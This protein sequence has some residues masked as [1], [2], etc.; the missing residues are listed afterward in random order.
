MSEDQMMKRCKDAKFFGIGYLPDYKLGFTRYSN[1]RESAVA[2]ILVYPGEN[3]WGILYSL[4]E[5]DIKELDKC[6]G[7]P[8]AYRRIDERAMLFNDPYDFEKLFDMVKENNFEILKTNYSDKNNYKEVNVITYEVVNKNV[9]KLYPS[10]EYLGIMQ[11]AAFENYFPGYYQEMLYNIGKPGRDKK[12]AASLDFFSGLLSIVHNNS[13]PAGLKEENEWGGAD[14]VIT[15]SEERKNFLNSNY[16]EDLVVLTPHWKELSWLIK[17]IYSN[18]SVTWQ[19]NYSNKH[20]F[21]KLLGV[22]ALEYQM[23]HPEDSSAMGICDA[24]LTEAYKQLTI[25]QKI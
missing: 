18:E 16:P 7:H 22:S 21:L 6:E 10:V 5:E 2:D 23:E 19:I 17:N 11:D 1:K 4:S 24:V 14:L 12:L 13:Y 25:E 8:T 3:V 9:E 20:Y 15:G